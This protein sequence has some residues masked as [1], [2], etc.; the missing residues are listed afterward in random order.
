MAMSEVL[1][2]QNGA[3]LTVTLNRPHRRNALTYTSFRLLADTWD[4]ADQNPD[5]R[6][7]I[8][9]GAGD[10]FCSGMD[11]RA[12]SDRQSEGGIAASTE[13]SRVYDALL[14]D[15]RPRQPLIAAVEGSAVA[16]GA[17]LLLGT[18]IRVA[19][20]NARFGLPEVSWG[21]Y[22]EGGGAVRLPR[23][24]PVALAADLL[25][26]GRTITAV[27]A[28]EAGLF[29]Q[30]VPAGQSLAKARELAAAIAA[31]GPLAVEAV[32]RTLRETLTL[33]EQ[34]AYAHDHPYATA[35]NHS[36]DAREGPAAFV[37]RRT[38]VFH[39]H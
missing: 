6:V 2:E 12:L 30:L 26:T 29:S 32:L 38:P 35:V 7:I 5:I 21:L 36:Q 13:D 27:E 17:E 37:A 33:S 16:G 24:M 9:T 18:D 34:D 11:L 15:R 14:R 8:V 23:Q 19:A 4:R 3:V 28:R 1:V 25:L 39:R 31:N 10:S 20:E 22:P